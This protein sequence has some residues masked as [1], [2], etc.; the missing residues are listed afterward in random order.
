MGG[1]PVKCV[2][3]ILRLL[4]LSHGQAVLL[5][6]SEVPLMM[7]G[8]AQSPLP[9][10]P[11]SADEMAE[12]LTEIV[13][14]SV[15]ARLRDTG[16]VDYT[17]P[18][19]AD[20]AELSITAIGNGE[21]IWLEV[22]P[23]FADAAPTTAPTAAPTPF[24]TR[25][26]AAEPVAA[27]RRRRIETCD[28]VNALIARLAGQSDSS[29]FLHSGMPP[30]VKTDGAVEWL[31]DFEPLAA[32]DLGRIL[33]DLSGEPGRHGGSGD[34]ETLSWTIPDVARVECRASLSSPSVQVTFRIKSTRPPDAGRLAIPAG[35]IA[36]CRDDYGLV[37][38][39]GVTLEHVGTT[40][41]GLV[42]L[43]N[44]E[45]PHH[46]I[47][48]ERQAVTRHPRGAAFLSHRVVSGDD[49]A[50]AAALTA[51]LA[52]APD[53]LVTQHVPSWELLDQL[54]AHAADTLII[55]QL[56]APSVVAA[57]KTLVA[58]APD[59]QQGEALGRLADVLAAALAQCEV[60]P[61]GTGGV[62]AYEVMLATPGVRDL[63]RQGAF[64]QLALTLERGVDGMIPMSAAI[65]ELGRTG[66]IGARQARLAAPAADAGP[67]QRDAGRGDNRRDLA[68]VKDA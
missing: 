37:T 21:D 12:I 33:V 36:A 52:E 46:V 17:V 60:K 45:C 11:L 59:G 49:A 58:F 39:S 25:A 24:E 50:W 42:D 48:L 1:V 35:V 62:S 38:M 16:S 31:D 3:S 57:L 8:T 61:R 56:E 2:D 7:T 68:L 26:G 64:D 67:F 28:D 41:H 29:L 63:V 13:P 47:V 32:D 30:A 20:R 51:A 44:R 54:L 53:V 40:C 34:D 23:Q 9:R 6:A 10:P 66:R 65:A 43:I 22:R 18:S 15:R 27:P 5:R 4:L 55:V 14:L 19:T